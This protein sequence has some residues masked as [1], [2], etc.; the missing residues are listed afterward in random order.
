MGFFGNVPRAPIIQIDPDTLRITD[1]LDTDLSHYFDI[2]IDDVNNYVLFNPKIGD[3]RIQDPDDAGNT[4]YLQITSDPALGGIL[5]NSSRITDGFIWEIKATGTID[6][7]GATVAIDYLHLDLDALV[8]NDAVANALTIQGIALD[9]NGATLTAVGLSTLYGFSIDLAADLSG[10]LT[11][12][13]IHLTGDG[14]VIDIC[15]SDIGINLSGTFS[16]EVVLIGGTYDHGIRFSEDPAAGDADNS[17][18]NIGEYGTAIAVAPAGANMFGEMHNVILTDVDVAFWY[19]GKYTKITTAGTTTATSVA[20][21]AIRMQIGSDLEAVYGI[22]CHTNITATNVCNQEIISVSALVDLA[23]ATVTTTDRV[24]ALQAAF[25]GAGAAGTVVGDAIVGYFVNGG[26]IVTTDAIIKVFNQAAAITSNMIHIE[27]D[28]A[29]INAPVGILFE[30]SL[31]PAID[32]S[33]RGTYSGRIEQ[34]AYN[35]EDDFDNRAAKPEWVARI[36]TGSTGGAGVSTDL[37]G[38]NQLITAG[39]AT[40]E[41]SL[42]WNDIFTFVN[43]LRPTFEVRVYLEDIGNDSNYAFG[44]VNSNIGNGQ[45]GLALNQGGALNQDFLIIELSHTTHGDALWHLSSQ[46]N[47]VSTVDDGAAAA[48]TTWVTLRFEFVTD[49]S[50]EWF[51]DN[52]SQG[53]ID[54]NVPTDPLQPILFALTDA[55]ATRYVDVDYVKIWQ[56][57]S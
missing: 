24:V 42:D 2:T 34:G 53:T 39:V 23:A 46:L 9:F 4:D 38:V 18:I 50:V 11:V 21:D 17:F 43:T 35:Y 48:A 30:G 5:Q 16:E 57:R 45:A 6:G 56:D 1:L 13:G 31:R 15:N 10:F 33:Q 36:T 14:Q 54:T 41:E 7:T 47:G 8:L 20:A 32:A 28:G 37:N 49:T 40:N 29:A 55:G 25:S 27:N 22:Q 3:L 12:A 26:T 51:I 52:V 44:L 19:Q